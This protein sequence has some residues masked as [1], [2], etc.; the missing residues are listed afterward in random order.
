METISSEIR[1][2]KSDFE[3]NSNEAFVLGEKKSFFDYIS[4]VLSFISIP[5]VFP[6]TLSCTVVFTIVYFMLFENIIN[7]FYIHALLCASFVFLGLFLIFGFFLFMVIGEVAPYHEVYIFL[8]DK[9]VVTSED[10]FFHDIDEEFSWKSLE[11]IKFKDEGEV[12]LDFEEEECQFDI[13]Y[14]SGVD[15]IQSELYNME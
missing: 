1:V 6:F 4:N 14:D 2:A 9:L 8:D 10:R 13:P 15:G 5:V 12:V 7:N 3:Y 11:D